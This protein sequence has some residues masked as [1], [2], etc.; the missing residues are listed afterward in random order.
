MHYI[1]QMY[2]KK[3]FLREYIRGIC[4]KEHICENMT[5]DFAK[6]SKTYCDL[7]CKCQSHKLKLPQG[8]FN[9]STQIQQDTMFLKGLQNPPLYGGERLSGPTFVYDYLWIQTKLVFYYKF[10]WTGRSKSH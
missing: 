5:S 6:V 10:I 9:F 8:N 7:L 4:L 3:P 1:L 2:K